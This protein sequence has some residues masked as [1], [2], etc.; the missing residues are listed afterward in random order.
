[1]LILCN[2]TNLFLFRWINRMDSHH[3]LYLSLAAAVAAFFFTSKVFLLPER[4]MITWLAY[5]AT[6][7]LFCW[8]TILTCH[9]IEVRQNA[10]I[11]D[12]SRSLIF[13]FVV[14]AA[15]VSL[16]AVILLLK[17]ARN[18][19]GG[20]QTKHILLSIAS[21]FGS[22]WLVHTI[23][24]FRYAHLYYS[25]SHKESATARIKGGLEFPKEPEPDYLDFT[26]FSFIIGMTFQVSDVE[27]SSR[28]IRRLAWMHSVI[29]FVFNTVIVALII[30][31]ISGLIQK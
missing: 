19:A 29:S 24:T 31:V 3:R 20:D 10:K 12:S 28:R 30:N 17:S 27:I 4:W 18:L 6:N 15:V 9:P 16:F 13:I 26:Y 8:I 1:M 22:W 7:L 2:M 25:I 23:F 14:L 5:A 11:Q 21:V